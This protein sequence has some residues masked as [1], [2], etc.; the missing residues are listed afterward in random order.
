MLEWKKLGEVC[1]SLKKEII[2]QDNLDD[3]GTYPVINSG[4]TLY[5]R[6]NDYNNDGNAFTFASRGEYAGFLTYVGE[7]FW[8]GG[9][10]YPYRSKNEKSLLT[11]YI[12]S[13]LKNNEK[14]IMDTLVMR[15]GIP[16]LN[17]VDVEKI[18]IPIPSLSEQSRI[19]SI[20][21]TF[22]DSI[23]NLK[24]QIEQRRKQYEHYRDQL[25]DLEGKEGVELLLL[26]DVCEV[27]NGRAY[28]Q[29]EL[30][31]V[32]KYRVLRVGN[33]FSNDSWYYSDLE[34]DDKYYCNNS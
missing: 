30:L 14:M 1:A 9:L 23:D 6:Y 28:S 22:T 12:Y 19:V 2:K 17:K 34:L 25:L 18:L 10:C 16:A 27:L 26:K 5:G 32:G 11:K 3:K 7:K 20:L 8:A 24:Q 29:P 21:D 4:V 15:G 31:S 33:F 13:Y